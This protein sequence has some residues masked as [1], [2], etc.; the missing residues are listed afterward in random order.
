MTS[1][2]KEL[3]EL[4]SE[5]IDLAKEYVR[6][7]IADPAKKLGR[8]A[9]MGFAA[10]FVFF[11]AALFL[12]IA[13]TRAIIMLL[14]DGSIWSGFGYIISSIALLMVTGIIMWRASQ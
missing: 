6:G 14:P 11:L 10:G 9:G 5:F 7:Q 8:L 13:G 4:I 2:V 3:P 1:R 12:A